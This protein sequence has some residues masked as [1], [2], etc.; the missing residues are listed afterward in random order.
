MVFLPKL[1][2][3]LAQQKLVDGARRID[4]EL[5]TEDLLEDADVDFDKSDIKLLMELA[6][7]MA[8]SV[9]ATSEWGM[10]SSDDIEQMGAKWTEN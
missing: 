1:L 10:A 3:L 2:L 9:R 7:C 4:M 6:M 5:D 8:D